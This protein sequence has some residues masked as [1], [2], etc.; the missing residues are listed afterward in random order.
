VTSTGPVRKAGGAAAVD[1][2]RATGQRLRQALVEYRSAFGEA[3]RR[4]ARE[5]RAE[6]PPANREEGPVDAGARGASSPGFDDLRED[7]ERTVA[8]FRDTVD[9]IGTAQKTRGRE[10]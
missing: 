2:V 3:A 10:R 5:A 4:L 8:V 6:G 7:W 1:Q 9:R